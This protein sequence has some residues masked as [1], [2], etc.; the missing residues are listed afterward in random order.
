MSR[1]GLLRS[2]TMLLC[3]LHSGHALATERHVP[4]E[5]PTIQQ[6][7]NAAVSGDTVRIAP[8]NYTE[9]VVVA[10]KTGLT[11]AGEPG[12]VLHAFPGMGASLAA[13]G[14][15]NPAVCAIYRSDVVVSG[16]HF[17]G[18]SL[19]GSVALTLDGLLFM[20][21][22]GMI[23]NCTFSGFRGVGSSEDTLVRTL[24]CRNPVSIG[25]G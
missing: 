10:F 8:G 7:V 4:A 3:V 19:G 11:L 5:Y 20:G 21:A 24:Y 18:E 17:E 13:Y 2:A 25:V 23:T 16:V 14:W 9:Q 12:T 15:N 1:F 22:E 6:A